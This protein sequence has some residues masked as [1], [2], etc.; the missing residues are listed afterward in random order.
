MIAYCKKFDW[1]C[2]SAHLW[3]HISQI[4]STKGRLHTSTNSNLL[5]CRHVT[6]L[7]TSVHP[8]EH[9]SKIK[10][11][12]GIADALHLLLCC[13]TSNTVFASYI[14]KHCSQWLGKRLLVS[15]LR[16]GGGPKV[17]SAHAAFVLLTCTWPRQDMLDTASTATAAYLLRHCWFIETLLSS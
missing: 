9:V 13:E 14:W 2:R 11:I 1:L 6:R 15:F 4:Q 10:S 16:V 8:W 7:C 5:R 3:E 12:Q 17:L